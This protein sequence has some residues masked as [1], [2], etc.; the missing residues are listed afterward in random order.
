MIQTLCSKKLYKMFFFS[1]DRYPITF[2]LR[3]T[4]LSGSDLAFPVYCSHAV[5]HFQLKLIGLDWAQDRATK[6]T[7]RAVCVS[8]P[9]SDHNPDPVAGMRNF[10][11]QKTFP[12]K[13]ANCLLLIWLPSRSLAFL[14]SIDDVL[15]NLLRWKM[16]EKLWLNGIAGD[17][18]WSF[19]AENQERLV[20]L[21]YSVNWQFYS[22]E[23]DH[24]I[25]QNKPSRKFTHHPSETKFKNKNTSSP[26]ATYFHEQLW[27]E[28][29]P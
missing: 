26:K 16:E 17:S 1:I 8:L 24:R 12:V 6:P 11:R 22:A 14:M 27:G 15:R 7:P 29:L 21:M 5:S 2:S 25:K 4:Q 18:T 28:I 13:R 19:L 9:C 20:T 10:E 23:Q 3:D